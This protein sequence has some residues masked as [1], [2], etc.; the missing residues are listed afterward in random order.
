MMIHV[1]EANFNETVLQS[2][3]PFIYVMGASWC[4]DCRRAEPFVRKLLETYGDRVAFGNSDFDADA[5]LRE[6]LDIRSIPTF[7]LYKK[8]ELVATLVDHKDNASLKALFEKAVA[9]PTKNPQNAP[10]GRVK[11]P[12]LLI[13][14][15]WKASDRR[16]FLFGGGGLRVVG[17]P[18]VEFVG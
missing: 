6:K 17:K 16:F 5:G 4:P 3:K 13:F 7:K 10:K 8:G 15:G 1:T 2:E 14:A 18:S 9:R 12:A 11:F